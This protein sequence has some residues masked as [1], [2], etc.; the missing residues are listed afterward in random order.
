VAS[1]QAACQNLIGNSV[2]QHCFILWQESPLV[3]LHRS[4]CDLEKAFAV[5]LYVATTATSSHLV[6]LRLIELSVFPNE[7]NI[8]VDSTGRYL[9]RDSSISPT[10]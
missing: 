6:P 3:V 4:C 10:P 2:C 8:C 5:T 9:L 1:S 7:I